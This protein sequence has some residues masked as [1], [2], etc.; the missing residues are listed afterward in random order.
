MEKGKYWVV[1]ANNA[2][3]KKSCAKISVRFP[4]QKLF[5]QTIMDYTQTINK[6]S[7]WFD[8]YAHSFECGP[9][10]LHEAALLKH[11]HT[12]QVCCNMDS[13]CK[14]IS[15]GNPLLFTAQITALFH[16]VGR[17]QQ[18]KD[19]NTFQDRK[20]VN[21]SQLGLKVIDEYHLLD[22]LPQ[23][24]SHKIRTAIL[25]H[26][27]RTIPDNLA[28]DQDL[29]CRLIRDAD[30]LDIYSIVASH[31]SNPSQVRKEIFETGLP[32][33]P[34]VTP[35]ICSAV[36]SGSTVDFSMIKCLNDFKL[37]Q[38]G[39]VYDLNFTR[40]FQLLK[41][42]GHFEQITAQLPLIPEVIHAIELARRYLEK[43]AS[44]RFTAYSIYSEAPE[45]VPRL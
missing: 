16:D 22:D 20:S 1:P 14:S 38:V 28:K 39:W 19:H 4:S 6:L 42:R 15:L 9:Q 2:Q 7:R 5:S 33:L 37:I 34:T 11:E 26:S 25:Y 17:F 41:E 35:Q 18:Y 27:A 31:Y 24:L 12:R 32:D 29:L 36:A 8:D 23:D 40:S 30:K 45:G 44:Q 13:L 43:C 21:H 10:Q 3:N